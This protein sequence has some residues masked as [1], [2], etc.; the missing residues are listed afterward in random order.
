[1]PFQSC[2]FSASHRHVQAGGDKLG[3]CCY[4]SCTG[5][6]L[7]A[8]CLHWGL[9]WNTT[10]QVIHRK[11]RAEGSAAAGS[12]FVEEVCWSWCLLWELGALPWG[13]HPR[14]LAKQSLKADFSL[15]EEV[16]LGQYNRGVG[17]A[18][19]LRLGS[20]ASCQSQSRPWKKRQHQAPS[21][22]LCMRRRSAYQN[23]RFPEGAR[24]GMRMEPAPSRACS[25]WPC[26]SCTPGPAALP[27]RSAEWRKGWGPHHQPWRGKPRGAERL[28]C[29][30]E[31][32]QCPCTLAW[33][34][35]W[36]QP[37]DTGHLLG[38]QHGADRALGCCVW[39]RGA[40]L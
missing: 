12:S 37:C 13:V 30:L 25:V 32:R 16:S 34:K 18:P 8:F 33:P 9:L 20:W 22:E 7:L 3:S 21:L 4:G 24:P 40:A 35:A 36:V 17:A 1:M 38:R 19:A 6:S 26:P 39:A 27:L 31:G 11:L 2:T 14:Y 28:E 10:T 23:L 15:I 5:L 29:Q